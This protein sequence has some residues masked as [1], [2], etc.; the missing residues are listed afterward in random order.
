MRIKLEADLDR[1]PRDG[2]GGIKRTN[3]CAAVSRHALAPA[4]PKRANLD[5]RLGW[6]SHELCRRL[7]TLRQ[8]GRCKA[9]GGEEC[10]RQNEEAPIADHP[11]VS[12]IRLCGLI[13]EQVSHNEGN[14]GR[15]FGES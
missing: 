15:S 13:S 7:Q 4:Q 9:D 3:D 6:L 5:F 8:C 14:I 11:L 2:A 1:V 12:K 10:P